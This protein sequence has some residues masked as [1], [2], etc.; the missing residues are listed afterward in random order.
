ME[1]APSFSPP[2]A[3]LAIGLAQQGRPMAALQSL[4]DAIRLDP[5]L[6][7]SAALWVIRA[8]LLRGVGRTAEA[9]EL[10]E[11]AREANPDL[12]LPRLELA[13]H[14]VSGGRLDEARRLA[15]EIRRV[16]PEMT[17][18]RARELLRGMTGRGPEE[19]SRLSDNLRA[20]GLP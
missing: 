11:Q 6:G 1:L 2:H 13:D 20:A 8:G 18:M 4:H 15:D 9:V 16:N 12:I 10:W 5:R 19:S 17:A 14:H 7:E 3:F